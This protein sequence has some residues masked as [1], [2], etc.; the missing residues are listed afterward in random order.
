MIISTED[1]N[2]LLAVEHEDSRRKQIVNKDEINPDED[3][4]KERQALK[5]RK[6][7]G[8]QRAKRLRASKRNGNAD[9]RNRQLAAEQILKYRDLKIEKKQLDPKKVSQDELYAFKKQMIERRQEAKRGRYLKRTN[10]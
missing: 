2:K 6:P 5:K 7:T 3:S 1:G 8:K 4:I 10:D 9:R